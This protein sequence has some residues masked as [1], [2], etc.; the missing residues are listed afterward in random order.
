MCILSSRKNAIDHSTKYN[1]HTIKLGD[2]LMKHATQRSRYAVDTRKECRSTSQA[3]R[4][5]TTPGTDL[6]T[7]LKNGKRSGLRLLRS[8]NQP[9]VRVSNRA[10]LPLL[11]RILFLI[12]TCA[13]L[14]DYDNA[15]RRSSGAQ[16]FKQASREAKRTIARPVYKKITGR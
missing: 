7:E 16:E 3:P 12:I 2:S 10:L 8:L 15:T 6:S 14:D 4:P 1:E 11:R 13:L 5:S 9:G